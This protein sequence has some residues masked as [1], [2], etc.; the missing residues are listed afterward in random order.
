M[1]ENA[2]KAATS[3]HEL[4]DFIAHE[5][6]NPLAAARS[7]CSFVS[8][9]VNEYEPLVDQESRICVRDDVRIIEA[10]LQFSNDLLQSMLDLHRARSKQLTLEY[11][12]TDMQRDVL[13]PVAT[14]LYSR[15]ES[16]EVIVECPET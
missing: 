12:P 6:Q 7:A 16:F 1:V 11:F 15:D 4:T 9:S 2:Q 3:E 8:A 14:M 13:E 10:S 5:V